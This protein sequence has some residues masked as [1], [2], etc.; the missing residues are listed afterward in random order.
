MQ[1]LSQSGDVVES[2]TRTDP[3]IVATDGLPQSRGALAMARA[4]AG[5]LHATI[6]VVAVHQSPALMAPD[7]QL[8]LDPNVTASL[9]ADLTRRVRDQCT[10]SRRD[11]A[12]AEEVEVL[13]GEPARVIS[14]VAASRNAQMI[15]VGIGRHE[16]VDRIFGDETALKVARSSRLPVLAVPDNDFGV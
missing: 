9:R 5:R 11:G 4:L 6:D 2:A 13:N 3:I 1:T 7:G 15:V 14:D 10:H 12:P 16:L 8:L